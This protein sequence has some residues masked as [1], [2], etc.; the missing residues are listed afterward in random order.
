MAEQLAS[1][2]KQGETLSETTLWTNPNP[3]SQFTPQTITLSDNI[4][5][6]KQ[7][8]LRFK[9]HYSLT[10]PEDEYYNQFQYT[11]KFIEN[12][13]WIFGMAGSRSQPTGQLG[14]RNMY[15]ISNTSI[16]FSNAYRTVST[17]PNND[18]PTPIAIIGLK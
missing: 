10:P 15:Y 9:G 12:V 11:D 4:Q 8:K 1:L 18:W 13:S 14:C 16:G 3:T 6:Y 5:N 2:R 7:I 17:S